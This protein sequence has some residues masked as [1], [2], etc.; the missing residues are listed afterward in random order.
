MNVLTSILVGLIVG[1]IARLQMPRGEPG[2]F[3]LT[4]LI[5]ILG[6]ELARLIGPL[7][8][9]YGPGGVTGFVAS[10]AGAILLLVLYRRFQME[11]TRRG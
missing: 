6:A 2:G 4:I 11:N 9:L 8:G 1:V 10:L 7:L 3:L 5:G